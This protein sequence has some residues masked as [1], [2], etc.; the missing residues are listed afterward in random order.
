M[1]DQFIELQNKTELLGIIG[2]LK[3]ISKS[4]WAYRLEDRMA[5]HRAALALQEVYN[6]L[7]ERQKDI[8]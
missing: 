4:K 1:V 7:A 6:R 2:S 5:L 8:E 3:R